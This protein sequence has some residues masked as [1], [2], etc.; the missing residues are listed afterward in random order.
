M[1]KPNRKRLKLETVRAQRLEAQ[2]DKYCEVEFQDAEGEE[3]VVRLL[4]QSW[5]PLPLMKE[6]SG[7][8]KLAEADGELE[9]A[10]VLSGL[11]TSIDVLR[12]VAHVNDKDAFEQLVADMTVGDFNAVMELVTSEDET[13][14]A[15]GESS[16]SSD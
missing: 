1:S 11:E 3:Q 16:G 5:W 6:L 15:Q 14:V 13:G 8:S 10:E 2:G 9:G 7:L 4:R 12:K